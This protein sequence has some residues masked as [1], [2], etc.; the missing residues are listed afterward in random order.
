VSF[1][2]CTSLTTDRRATKRLW[3]AETHVR[4]FVGQH[5]G[6]IADFDLGVANFAAGLLH[7][8]QLFGA[9]RFLVEL[10]CTGANPVPPFDT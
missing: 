6:R 1:A 5:D 2:R 3:A 4:V 9:K 7:T 8:R 10:D